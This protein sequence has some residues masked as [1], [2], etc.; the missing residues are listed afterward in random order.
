M[1]A[2]LNILI[3]F[4]E[5]HRG[6]CLSAAGHPVLLTPNMD[7]IGGQGTRFTSAYTTC[8]V[9][10]PARRSLISGQY[11][12]THG[13]YANINE[14][15][16]PENTLGSTLRDAGYQTGWVGRSMHQ[17]PMRKRFGFE[18]VVLCGPCRDDDYAEF[19]A[20]TCPREAAG[21]MVAV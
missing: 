17:Y 7:S 4:A 10:V 8:P 14:V 6:D 11:P 9:C 20:A 18:E 13:A 1:A 21:T 5:Q 3:L 12:S 2:R 15:W 19:L 16:N